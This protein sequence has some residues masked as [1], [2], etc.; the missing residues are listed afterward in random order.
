M[1][2]PRRAGSSDTCRPKK[3]INT[4]DA[5]HRGYVVLIKWLQSALIPFVTTQPRSEASSGVGGIKASARVI[6][7]E[8]Y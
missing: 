8:R 2:E 4:P 6:N 7:Y 3:L 5:E 1:S